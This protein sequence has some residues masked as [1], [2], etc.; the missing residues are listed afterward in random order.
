MQAKRWV[1][2]SIV[3]SLI[4][5]F[6]V[7]DLGQYFNIA[8]MRQQQSVIQDYYLAHPFLAISGFFFFYLTAAALSLPG[9]GFLSLLAGAVFGVT[10]GTIIVS[11]GS[12]LGATLAFLGARFLF[13]ENI[14][15]RFGRY[16][17]NINEGL[18]RDGALYLFSLRLIPLFPFFI[19]NPVM[20]ITRIKTWTFMWVSQLGMLAATIIYVNAGT[21]LA[22]LTTHKSIV[23]S[24]VWISLGLLCLFPWLAK[25]CISRWQNM[26]AYRHFKKPKKFDYNI[27][28]IGA[29]SAGLVSAYIAATVNAKV[30]LIEKHK[31][32]GDCLNTGCVPSKALLRTAKLRHQMQHASRYGLEDITVD[33]PFAKTLARV[34]DIIKKIEPHDSVERYTALGVDCIQGE[35]H[36]ISPWEV[37]VD[38]KTLTTRNIIIATGASPMPLDIKDLDKVAHYT[39]D[40][41]WNIKEQPKNL[42]VMGGGPIGCELAQCFARLGSKVTIVT[43]GARLLPKEDLEVSQTLEAAFMQEGILIE[44]GFTAD[45]VSA[46][47]HDNKHLHCVNAKGE[48]ITLA[49]DALLIAVGRKANTPNLDLEKLG[50]RC[51]DNGTILTNDYLQTDVPNIYA[52]GDVTSPY[53]FTHTASHQAWYCAVN[54]LFGTFKKFRVDYSVIPWCTFTDPEIAHVGLNESMALEQQI[55]YEITR[56]ELNDLDRAIADSAT[57]GFVKI[58]TPPGKD[59]ILG[60]TIV[61]EHAGDLLA[62]CVLAMKH[63]IGLNKLLGTIHIYPTLAEANKYAAGNWKKAHKPALILRG[64]RRYHQWRRH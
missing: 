58:L 48:I 44:K 53:Q 18:D 24:D 57:Q 34:H 45:H 21:Q 60:I 51:R 10:I 49:C 30:A 20:G 54:A 55:P 29:G 40:T 14:E 37:R 42:I 5:I 52:C 47:A 36:I 43:Q 23:S 27:V 15:A 9:A 2:A 61:G 16:L 59:R 8:V 1:L 6:Y 63:G 31:M 38:N 64:L 56:Y 19:I 39:S 62:E 13:R 26:R 17:K 7:F 12:T 50:I 35:A 22:S 41:I 46:D 28:V 33:T 4:I 32:G 25:F 11:F 3:I